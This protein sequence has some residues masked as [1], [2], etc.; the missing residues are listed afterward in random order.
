MGVKQTNKQKKTSNP[1]YECQLSSTLVV[2]PSVV[3]LVQQPDLPYRANSLHKT[4]VPIKLS[5]KKKKKSIKE[6]SIYLFGCKIRVN[7]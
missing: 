3:L 6:G 1:Y 2:A 4:C 5:F 7:K